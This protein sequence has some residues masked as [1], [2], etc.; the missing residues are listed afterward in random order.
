MSNKTFSLITV[1]IN[2]KSILTRKFRMKGLPD[3]KD[4]KVPVIE[5]ISRARRK[6]RLKSVLSIQM[7][8]MTEARLSDCSKNGTGNYIYGTYVLSMMSPFLSSRNMSKRSSNA[9]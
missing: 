2:N 8:H 9:Y 1:K 5:R 6:P 3:K 4:I 7:Q